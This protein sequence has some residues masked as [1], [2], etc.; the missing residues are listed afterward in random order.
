MLKTLLT[1]HCIII[2]G[3]RI[4]DR[5][6]TR[7]H[8]RGHWFPGDR[9]PLWLEVDFCCAGVHATSYNCWRHSGAT[10]DGI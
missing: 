4:Q 6:S 5:N 8:S 9:V 3:H 2:T 10:T 7:V 1:I